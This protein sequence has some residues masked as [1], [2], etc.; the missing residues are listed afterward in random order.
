[1]LF[2]RKNN[3][4]TSRYT[5]DEGL[6][7]DAVLNIL[8]DGKGNLWLSTYNGLSKFNIAS[9]T[10]KNYYQSDGLQS[11]QFNYNAALALRSG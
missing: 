7:N 4:I 2:D 3:T 6:C 10:F 5:T 1:M 8:D 11:N 9:R